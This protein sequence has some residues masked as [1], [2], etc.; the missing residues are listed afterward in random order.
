MTDD[1]ISSLKIEVRLDVALS[2]VRRLSAQQRKI[3]CTLH[4]YPDLCDKQ[5]T[6]YCFTDERSIT[7]SLETLAEKG[8]L[9]KSKDSGDNRKTLWR[10]CDQEI[11]D[12]MTI[13]YLRPGQFISWG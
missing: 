12:A 6:R 2:R 5:I 13:K 3:V 11:F 10:I 4:D 8:I 9:S 7:T 1:K